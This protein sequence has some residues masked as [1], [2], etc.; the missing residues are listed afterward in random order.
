MQ[1]P[2]DVCGI[3][4]QFL[5]ATALFRSINS[6]HLFRAWFSID[7][8]PA[9]WRAA[10]RHVA[11]KYILR[12]STFRTINRFDDWFVF[13]LS[14]LHQSIHWQIQQRPATAGR[15]EK[16]SWLVAA[17]D[18]V[19]RTTGAW[20]FTGD[21]DHMSPSA[22][23]WWDVLWYACDGGDLALVGRLVAEFRPGALRLTTRRRAA[24]AFT[25]ACARGDISV[26]QWLAAR[27]DYP[28]RAPRTVRDAA[29]R[30]HGDAQVRHW[31]TVSFQTNCGPRSQRSRRGTAARRVEIV[32][33]RENAKRR[34]APKKGADGRT[35]GVICVRST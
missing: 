33:A 23:T 24:K 6:T 1:L 21:G 11:Q 8:A 31:L 27:F 17:C 16:L 13:R 32:V 30:Y 14:C 29:R 9:L 4:L 10:L 12:M 25:N 22:A 19:S 28:T 18:R 5:S 26:A 15:C 34:F 2:R 7:I 20:W 35:V 3:I